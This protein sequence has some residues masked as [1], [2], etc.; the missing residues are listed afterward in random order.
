MATADH[1]AFL[2]MPQLAANLASLTPGI[3]LM[4]PAQA[5]DNVELIAQSG[6]DL[7]IG[8]FDRLPARFHSRRLYDED[9]VCLVRK[10]HP[11][12]GETLTLDK[13]VDLSHVAVIIT[14]HEGAP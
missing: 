2:L 10:G 6:A 14:G 4:M 13:Y 1:L 9:P 8:S 11:V 7:A 3:D 12:I 5:G